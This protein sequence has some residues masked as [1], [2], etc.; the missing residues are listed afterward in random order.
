MSMGVAFFITAI[1][2]LIG[3]PWPL[4]TTPSIDHLPVANATA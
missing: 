2:D 1:V 4:T 3:L